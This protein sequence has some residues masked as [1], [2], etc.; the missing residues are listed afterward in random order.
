MVKNGIISDIKKPWIVLGD[1]NAV[2]YQVEKVGG[3][4]PNK[5]TRLDFKNCLK[6]CELIQAPKTGL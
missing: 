2:I 1:F 3:R 5:I 4:S 6:N